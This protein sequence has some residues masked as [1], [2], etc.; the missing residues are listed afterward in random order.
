M[1]P[2]LFPEFGFRTIKPVFEILCN[3][4]GPLV[5][6]IIQSHPLLRQFFVVVAHRFIQWIIVHAHVLLS[7]KKKNVSAS[8]EHINIFI[9]YGDLS[10]CGN[11]PE[12][13]KEKKNLLIRF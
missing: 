3:E 11:T 13:K 7:D 2:I 6:P 9:N 4:I 5:N 10:V 1:F 8:I 12:R